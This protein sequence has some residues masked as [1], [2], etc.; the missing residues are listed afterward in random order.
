MLAAGAGHRRRGRIAGLTRQS[1]DR[2]RLGF[3]GSLM[4]SK[5]PHVLLE[6]VA[7]LPAGPRVADH[8]RRRRALPR[9]RQ[10]RAASCARC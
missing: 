10:L 4:A 9:R 8:R 5:A 6:A 7:G 2:L 3:V 1:S